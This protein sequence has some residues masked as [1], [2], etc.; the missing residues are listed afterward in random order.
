MSVMPIMQSITV[1]GV[2]VFLMFGY[3]IIQRTGTSAIPRLAT[4]IFILYRLLPRIGG[5]NGALALINNDFP[6]VERVAAILRPDDKLYVQSGKQPFT[7][8]QRA[9]RFMDVT[10]QYPNSNQNAVSHLSFTIERSQMTAFVGASGAGKS[11]LVNLLLRLYDPTCGQLLADGINFRDLNL[12][13]WRSHVGIVDQETFIFSS[14]IADNIRF[15]NLQATDEQVIAAA[16]TA[17]AHEFIIQLKNGYDTEVGNRGYRLSGGQRQRIAI[18]R[19]IVRQPEILIFD[20]ATSALDSHSEQM[21]QAAL[22]DLRRD[23]TVI[24]IAHRLSTIAGADKIIVL[25]EGSISEQGTHA[26]LLA[27]DSIY[28]SLWKIQSGIRTHV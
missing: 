17:Y 14:T 11:T 24:A 25:T 22:Q 16:K 6:F 4:F 5:L 7:G 9:I 15:G 1:L 19:A 21:I 12:N 18:A 27:A 13:H 3:Q 10:L 26:E 8:L 23:R 2:V 20:E 28:A